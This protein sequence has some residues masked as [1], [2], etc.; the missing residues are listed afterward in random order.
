VVGDLTRHNKQRKIAAALY[1]KQSRR[2]IFQ[3]IKSG[4]CDLCALFSADGGK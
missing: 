3:K 4:G 2:F 1:K